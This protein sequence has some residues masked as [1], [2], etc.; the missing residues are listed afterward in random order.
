MRYNYSPIYQYHKAQIGIQACPVFELEKRDL[1]GHKWPFANRF[2]LY[3]DVP[4]MGF[5]K[6]GASSHGL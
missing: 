6:K 5:C 3:Q 1:Y 4:N 2:E